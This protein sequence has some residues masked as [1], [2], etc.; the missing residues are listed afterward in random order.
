MRDEDVSVQW[1]LAGPPLTISR[2][3]MARL[4]RHVHF[5]KHCGPPKIAFPTAKRLQAARLHH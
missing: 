5:A 3:R 4:V 1:N 2:R